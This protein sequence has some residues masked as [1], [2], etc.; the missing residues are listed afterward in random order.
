[1]LVY[2]WEFPTKYS[3]TIT[4]LREREAKFTL[5]MPRLD[6]YNIL[7]SDKWSGNFVSDYE[8]VMIPNIS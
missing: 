8:S 6:I 4:S 5:N 7:F 2:V 1:M 3:H